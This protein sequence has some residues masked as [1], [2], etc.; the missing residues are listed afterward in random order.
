VD[1]A[2]P[3][4]GIVSTVPNGKYAKLD[5]T[6]MACPH[7]A[8]AAALVWSKTFAS[9]TQDRTQMAT[10]RDL[11]YANARPIPALRSFWGY[12]APAKVPGGVLDL[13]FLN[14]TPSNGNNSGTPKLV[15][16]RMKVDPAK[17]R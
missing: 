6:S 17:L 10:V 2:A 5:G 13:S 9:P 12:N 1:I 14:S 8:G 16:F 4:V 15:E 11:I 7:V 3:G